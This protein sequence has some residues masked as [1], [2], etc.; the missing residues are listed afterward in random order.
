VAILVISLSSLA[1]SLYS[2]AG[3]APKPY[4]KSISY[5]LKC[6]TYSFWTTS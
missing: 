6:I 1:G 3:Q 2:L 5:Y 4:Q